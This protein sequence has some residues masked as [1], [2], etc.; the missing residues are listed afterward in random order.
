MTVESFTLPARPDAGAVA[1]RR[2]RATA[3][4]PL[5]HDAAETLYL[6][7]NELVAN[8][9]EHGDVP[10]P[11]EVSLTFHD[12]RGEV[13][14]VDSGTGCVPP[15][16]VVA[17]RPGAGLGLHVV[18]KAAERWGVSCDRRTR[19]WFEFSCAP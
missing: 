3:P 13:A 1:R 4:D 11:L 19:I 14:V 17:P 12:G 8:A 10:G 15:A 5:P 7:V 18:E 2:A 16:D 9:L 6:L